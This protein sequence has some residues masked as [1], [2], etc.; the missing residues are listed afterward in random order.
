MKNESQQR[1]SRWWIWSRDAPKGL[2][3]C[4]PS[5]ASESPE[6]TRQESQSLL[7]QQTEQHLRTGRPVVYSHSSSYSE[8]NVDETWS[9]Q[10]WKPDELMEDRTGQPVVN[11]QHTDKFIVENDNMDSY[12]GADSEISLESRSAKE[13]VP[14][15]KRFYYKRQRQTLC[16]MGNVYV[17]YITSICIHGEN[18]SDNLHSIKKY[19][20]SHNETDVRHIWE[21]VISLSHIYV[22][23]D[24]VLCLG[25]MN[26]NPQSNYAWEDRLMR[27]KFS[28]EYR[29]F[30]TIDG[31]PMEFQWNIFPGFTTLQLCNK[32]QEFMSKMSKEPEGFT[33][34]IIFMSMFN[35]I[36]WWSNDNEQECELSAQLVSMYA[37]RFSPGRWSF[38]G[39]GSEKKWNSTYIDRPRGER[40]RVAELMMFKFDESGH[41]VFR[42]TSPLSRGVL[43]SKGGG[44][45][46]IHVCAD[47]GTIVLCTITGSSG[48]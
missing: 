46:S 25:K 40:D 4:V 28:S 27:L 37:K 44:K 23:S 11:A 48:G 47:E 18:Y 29:I 34:R 30:D 22:F 7:S 16:D 17:I 2:L 13:A 10:E 15:F 42:S 38:L 31:E 1:R 32:V 14:I 36:S 5:T 45:L 9:S 39:L 21:I 43:T 20:R 6:K 8:W 12:T 41:P 35:D 24:S 3:T 26:E 19:R 33:G